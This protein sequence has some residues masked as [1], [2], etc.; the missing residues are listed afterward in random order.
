MPALRIVCTLG[1]F[2][3]T[4]ALIVVRPRGW[5]EGWWA[6][7]GAAAMLAL[8]LVTPTQAFEVVW[9]SRNTILFLLALLLL[10]A[11][12][13]SSGFFEW[14]ALHASRLA[15][16]DGRRL[17][18]NV[19]LL[20]AVVTTALSLDTT[21]VMLTPIVVAFVQRLRLPAGRTS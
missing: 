9:G 8:R 17:F 6:A 3:G 1:I 21:A 7:L 13:E 12:L 4:L 5:H 14:A 10:S 15:R 11:L 2:V 16:G 20:G 19:F 18:R